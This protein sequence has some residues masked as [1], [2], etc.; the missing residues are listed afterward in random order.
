MKNQVNKLM[1]KREEKISRKNK[2]GV[3]SRWE[4]QGSFTPLHMFST[5]GVTIRILKKRIRIN[6]LVIL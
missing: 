4:C 1:G 5:N 2:S 3:V 6:I